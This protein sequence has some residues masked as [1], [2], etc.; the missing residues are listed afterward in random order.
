MKLSWLPN[1]LTIGRIAG[2]LVCAVSILS[3]QPALA[4]TA[5]VL[6][7]LTDLLDGWLARALDAISAF[8]AWLDPI[9]DKL[10]AGLVLTALSLQSPSWTLIVPTGLIILRDAMVSHWR[11]RLGG[12]HAL[13]VLGHALPVLGLSK[14]KTALEMIAIGLLLAAPLASDGRSGAVVWSGLAC[15]WLAALASVLTG[16]KYFRA[17]RTALAA[18]RP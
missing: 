9:A 2:A 11:M 13:P 8:G 5:F 18:R 10:L 17:A 14:W 3:D 15:L 1:S 16:L 6:A 12:G 4:L 7:A